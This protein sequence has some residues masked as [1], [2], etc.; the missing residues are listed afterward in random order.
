MSLQ[1]AE[2]KT[3]NPAPQGTHIARCVQMV[4]LG[5]QETPFGTKR[6]VWLQWELPDEPMDDGRP[7][8]IGK[9]YTAS[10]TK[11]SNLRLDLEAWRGR[12]FTQDE[13]KAFDLRKVLGA[14]CLVSVKHVEK[15]G[16]VY[17]NVASIA[18]APKG[19]TVPE[20]MNPP[21]AF[22]IDEPDSEV[23]R[24]LPEWLQKAIQSSHERGGAPE[25]PALK[26]V[27]NSSTP[28]ATEAEED[29]LDDDIP[30]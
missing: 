9:R 21:L 25:K 24:L 13:L 2:N 4:D 23:F 19:M 17:A 26:V 1:V 27:D 11:K 10:L 12:A 14:P 16:N 22:D 5:T 3:F 20:A 7:F 28:E 18:A 29:G 8:V 15:D 6:Q 30:F